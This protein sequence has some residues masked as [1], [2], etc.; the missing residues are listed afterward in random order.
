MN[1]TILCLVDDFGQVIGSTFSALEDN[2]VLKSN[3]T[4]YC[5]SAN[6][7]SYEVTWSYTDPVGTRVELFSTTNSTTGVSMLLV[8]TT[9]PGY[10]GC[11]ISQDQLTSITFTAIMANIIAGLSLLY[12]SFILVDF[13]HLLIYV[14]S[15]VIWGNWLIALIGFVDFVYMESK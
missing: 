14:V 9:H 12:Q 2:A 15:T 10:Y 13:I 5:V 8:N 4:L 1:F 3:T 11:E 7:N 6:S